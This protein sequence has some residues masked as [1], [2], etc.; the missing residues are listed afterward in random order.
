MEK[1]REEFLGAMRKQLFGVE[2]ELTGITRRQTEQIIASY[3]KDGECFDT[4]GRDWEVVSDSKY[5]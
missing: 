2:I 3:L 1:K 4:C 5:Q